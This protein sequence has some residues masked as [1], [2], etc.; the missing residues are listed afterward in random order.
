MLEYRDLGEVGMNKSENIKVKG[1]F[2]VKTDVVIFSKRLANELINNYINKKS[3][4]VFYFY[5]S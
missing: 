3:Q 5:S 1:G 4:T 2:N